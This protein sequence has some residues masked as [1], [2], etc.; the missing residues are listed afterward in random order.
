MSYALLNTHKSYIGIYLTDECSSEKTILM[1]LMY[2]MELL[3]LCIGYKIILSRYADGIYMYYHIG[4]TY[5]ITKHRY[6]KYPDQ[7][8]PSVDDIGRYL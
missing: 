6:G 1:E 2:Y 8:Q 4:C 7:I 5:W 3:I